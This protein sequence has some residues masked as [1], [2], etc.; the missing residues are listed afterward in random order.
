MKKYQFPERNN[1]TTKNGV[2]LIVV[3]SPIPTHPNTDLIDQALE[4]VLKMNYPFS[5]MIIS[6]DKD[7]KN[8]SSYKTYKK[9]MKSK[10][11]ECKHLEL[12]KHGHFIGTFHNALNHCKTKHFL[13]LQHDIC[14][15]GTFPIDECLK[16]SLPWN[17]IATH[18]FSPDQCK[19]D[20]PESTHWFPIMKIAKDKNL[21]KSWGWSERI[22]LSK[23][24]WMMDKIHEYYH[25]GMTKDFIESIFH[26]EFDKLWK[27][28]QGITHFYDIS[29]EPQYMKI[30]DNFWLEWKTYNLKSSV[31]YHKH[32]H[33]RTA[34][35]TAKRLTKG[36]RTLKRKQRGGSGGIRKKQG[37]ES[38]RRRQERLQEKQEERL[39]R[40]Q[41]Q[42][43]T[44][45]EKAAEGAPFG[46]TTH[47]RH[48]EEGK[49]QIIIQGAD[50]DLDFEDLDY[51]GS[52]ESDLEE[53]RIERNKKLW[54]GSFEYVLPVDFYVKYESD[55][56][57][58]KYINN[59]K[60][61]DPD[62][63][64]YQG[65]DLNYRLH[66]LDTLIFTVPPERRRSL[67]DG[68]SDSLNM[69]MASI[70]KTKKKKKK[71][72]K[73]KTKKK[74]KKKENKKKI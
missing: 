62:G 60:I 23:R 30:Y 24:D 2:S 74:K 67:K 34:K 19:R 53:R 14:L 6:Y 48:A 43:Q 12:D 7:R 41:G 42:H 64:K 31:A 52:S 15:E 26:K 46:V 9:K 71:K 33:G 38:A 58:N 47:E 56:E 22:F 45:G 20:I 35:R 29:T 37:Q 5:E 44:P 70:R 66:G 65:G 49:G 39:L 25:K 72:K 13:L 27:R 10:Y 61:R 8:T 51:G 18:H 68:S 73:K 11:P 59:L 55:S 32:L 17:I 3:S 36:K 21:L 1:S 4:S 69:E 40:Q 50:D 57:K 28:V 63:R 54:P 16:T